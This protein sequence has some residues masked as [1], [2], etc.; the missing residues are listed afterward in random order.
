MDS[1]LRTSRI[2]AGPTM[3]ETETRKELQKL[4]VLLD[5]Q[6]QLPFGWRIGWDGILGLIPGL[7]DFATNIMSFY[8]L[9]K[10]ALL[11]CPPAVIARMGLN[12][13][14]DN[15]IDTIPLIGNLFDFVWKANLKN[16]QLMENYLSEPHRTVVA[17]RA[18]VAATILF[19]F[20]LVIGCLALTFFL[21]RWLWGFFQPTW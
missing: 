11:G 15:V 6:F 19:I 18:V 13:L 9:Y 16:V 2:S 21:A 1:T 8:I 5:S 20:A 14:I 12:L 7:G 10:A 17:S 3:T 4:S